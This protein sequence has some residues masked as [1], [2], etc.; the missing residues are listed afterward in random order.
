MFYFWRDHFL[1]PLSDF[2]GLLFFLISLVIV[3]VLP[4][5]QKNTLTLIILSLLLGFSSYLSYNIRTTYIINIIFIFIYLFFKKV[6]IKNKAFIIFFMIL[7]IL[8]A[9]IPQILVNLKNFNTF[10]IL[11]NQS[12][13]QQPFLIYALRDG[14]KIQ[15]YETNIDLQTYPK[16]AVE[17]I[18]PIGKLI[19]IDDINSIIDYLKIFIKRP[20]DFLGI[21]FRHFFNGLDIMYP[22]VYVTNIFRLNKSFSLIN[23]TNWFIFINFLYRNLKF[24]NNNFNFKITFLFS[25]LPIL[26]ILP[27][28]A[29]VR[30]YLPIYILSYGIVGYLISLKLYNIKKY[31]KKIIFELKN[32]NVNFYNFIKIILLY[33]IFII[34][35]FTLQAYTYNSLL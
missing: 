1:Y 16:N 35:C 8:I 10:S 4:K 33:F 27:I 3:L 23:Y 25:S 19:N 14:I 28:Y 11:V 15:K 22:T 24:Q 13:R 12:Y 9:S 7:G 32:K 29:E 34:T 2:P 17:F 20:F 26:F 31:I 5:F 18:D 6:S 30:Y 21:Y